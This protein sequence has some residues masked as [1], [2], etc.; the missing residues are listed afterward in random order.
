MILGIPLREQ[1]ETMHR[2]EFFFT[3]IVYLGTV[4]GIFM[5]GF[6]I[7]YISAEG[8]GLFTSVSPWDFLMS[9]VLASFWEQPGHLVF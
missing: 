5:M 4:L 9:A 8:V 3:A 2:S 1:G 7:I 6:L